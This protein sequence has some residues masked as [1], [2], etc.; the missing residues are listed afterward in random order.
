MC[1]DKALCRSSRDSSK[2]GGCTISQIQAL[3][4]THQQLHLHLQRPQS[5]RQSD[6]SHLPQRNRLHQKHRRRAR[7]EEL[8]RNV[9]I[10][11]KVQT[12]QTTFYFASDSSM[13]K[14]GWIGAIGKMVMSQ[15]RRWC[16]A[17]TCT[18][19]IED[20]PILFYVVS[21]VIIKPRA[22]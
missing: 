6:R 9:G 17:T 19:M 22:I 3:G 7:P 21:V 8:F 20:A 15:G 11:Q 2:A 14:Q 12:Q 10:I 13:D 16:A 5:L 1:R 18:W 4:R